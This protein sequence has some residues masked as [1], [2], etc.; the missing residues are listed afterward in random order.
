MH[1]LSFHAMTIWENIAIL[2]IFGFVMVMLAM[3]SFGRQE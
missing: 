2:A 1:N 3:W